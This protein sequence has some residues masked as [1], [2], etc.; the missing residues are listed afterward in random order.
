MDAPSI[1]DDCVRT[2]AAPSR[3][4]RV[5]GL[6]RVASSGDGVVSI[7]GRRLARWEPVLRRRRDPEIPSRKVALASERGVFVAFLASYAASS[8][9]WPRCHDVVNEAIQR[10]MD[11]HVEEK[12]LAPSRRSRFEMDLDTPAPRSRHL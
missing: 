12:C 6:D 4:A 3:S 2:F 1:K 9:D 11:C 10:A 5:S 8:H 7:A